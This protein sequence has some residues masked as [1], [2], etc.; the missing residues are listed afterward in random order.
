MPSEQEELRLTVSLVDNA[1][2]G[3]AALKNQI[4]SLT[5]GQTRQSFETFQR[6]QKDMG[7][8]I[9]DLTTAAVGG[10][11]ALV[12]YITRFGALGIA[13]AAGVASMKNLA[14][15]LNEINIAA[16][17]T[18]VPA[19]EIKNVTE[20]MAKYGISSKDALATIQGITKAT[21]EL[22]RMGSPQYQELMEKAGR[23]SGEMAGLVRQLERTQ[24]VH[25]QI[26]IVIEEGA[27]IAKNRHDQDIAMG[28]TEAEATRDAAQVQQEWFERLGTSAQTLLLIREKLRDAS[29]ED[30]AR[31]KEEL[32]DAEKLVDV[33][34]QLGVA[35]SN[36]ESV[37]FRA[38][39]P[40]LT[41][42]LKSTAADIQSIVNGINKVEEWWSGGH[43]GLPGG[44]VP[45]PG[46]ILPG[47][48]PHGGAQPFMSSPDDIGEWGMR[49][50]KN[51]I[52]MRGQSGGTGNPL[53]DNTKEL[54]KLNDNLFELLHP[55]A[56]SGGG[57]LGLFSGGTGGGGGFGGGGGAAPYGSDVGAGT[58][59]GAGATPA[60]KP[61]GGAAP[62]GGDLAAQ[63]GIN[64]P[65]LNPGGAGGGSGTL[66][67]SRAGFERELEGDPALKRYAI[68]AM[69]HEGGIQS[70]MEQ[71]FN[72][73]AMRHMTIRQALHS[74]QY[75]PVKRGLI[76]GN[77]SAKTNAAGEAALK[78]VYGGSNITDYA[79]DQGMAGDPNFA[80]YMSN[81]NY[82]HMHKVQGAWFSSHGEAGRKW[83]EQQRAADQQQTA[84]VD[85]GTPI[86]GTGADANRRALELA[87]DA[88]D[89][90]DRQADGGHQCAAWH[91]RLGQWHRRLQKGRGQSPG[92]NA[93]RRRRSCWRQ[94]TKLSNGIDPRAFRN[95]AEHWPAWHDLARPIVA[96][97]VCRRAVSLRVE[98]PRRRPARRHARISE[99]RSALH[100][101]HG[102]PRHEF[103]RAR[104]LHCLSVR[105]RH[106]ALP[107]R[108]PTA[109]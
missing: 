51:I 19:V 88:Q 108:L 62:G 72:Y 3:I 68:D 53:D 92:A 1:S 40:A 99:T 52:D 78:A 15:T 75:G 9:K 55:T 89:R 31:Y 10:E 41:E 48:A 7:A 4:Q 76:S 45:G 86:A 11:K 61:G 34:N 5:S 63:L 102:P 80:K 33:M 42:I 60:G 96:G 49:K 18:G 50:S 54:K 104:L 103:Q 64:S 27:I 87:A 56:G 22:G 97:D 17:M 26:N 84:R 58:G 83:A 71:L 12:G 59:D 35:V 24:D 2:A 85:V 57:A 101:D 20:Q 69:Q 25:E 82:W 29:P 93:Q 14:Q 16:K 107:A 23:Y 38:F 105:Y 109:A 30:A 79:T 91:Q 36:V 65:R 74:G 13:A 37:F 100:R 46:G 90:G 81:P 21:V 39:G 43:H 66:A 70:N 67:A 6:Q 8:Q 73:A 47:T 94:H 106:A 32:K 77:I 28:K 44:I 98:Q 95:R